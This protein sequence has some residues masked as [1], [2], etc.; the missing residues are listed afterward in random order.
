MYKK[1]T[2]VLL[3]TLILCSLVSA[4]ESVVQQLQPKINGS[5]SSYRFCVFGDT[6]TAA[7]SSL[8]GA[9]VVFQLARNK[10][11]EAVNRELKEKKSL[12]SLFTGDMIWIGGD[13]TYWSSPKNH[14]HKKHREKIFPIPGNHETWED[15][16][17][18]N[19][20]DFFTHLKGRHSYY[21][22]RGR[23]LYL[24]LCTGGYIGEYSK[25]SSFA[26]DQRFTCIQATY[27]EMHLE[28]LLSSVA[29]SLKKAGKPLQNIFV[30]YHKPSYSFYKH[31]P[32]DSANDPVEKLKL[33]GKRHPSVQMYVFNGHNHTTEMYKPT[34]NITVLVAG[35]GGAPQ[36]TL[37]PRCLAYSCCVPDSLKF[38]SPAV[39][40]IYEKKGVNELFWKS[41]GLTTWTRTERVN[42]WVVAV[43]DKKGEVT[44][45]EKVL[46]FSSDKSLFVDGLR[47]VNG[48]VV[49]E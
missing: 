21:F 3:L 14:F 6:R 1:S 7:D 39:Q 16:T 37:T 2:Q 44:L 40:D 15:S 23:S 31:P 11:F 4:G 12:F 43:N 18:H 29:D 5:E 9:D 41:I 19:Y 32:L 30:Q 10:V 49:K 22:T 26:Q 13:T 33:L 46:T 25:D 27:E 8:K 38:P 34:D 36:K 35:G 48:E 28:S 24:S 20:F 45:T 42:Y 47:L 17:L